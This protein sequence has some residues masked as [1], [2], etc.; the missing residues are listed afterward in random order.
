APARRASPQRQDAD[1][2]RGEPGDE[3]R[4]PFSGDGPPRLYGR[5][6]PTI[7]PALR[8]A[9]LLRQRAR[10]PASRRAPGPEPD[11]GAAAIDRRRVDDEG[12]RGKLLSAGLCLARA[13]FSEGSVRPWRPVRD[14][15]DV[16]TRTAE[17]A[18]TF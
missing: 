9:S 5:G 13:G 7:A 12:H 16:L 2:G 11:G 18:K 14:L 3:P 10:Q 15:G 1:R 6:D 4:R 17:R 8:A